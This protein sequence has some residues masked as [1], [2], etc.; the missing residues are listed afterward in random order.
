MMHSFGTGLGVAT[1][2]ANSIELSVSAASL[3]SRHFPL[4][5]DKTNLASNMH[6]NVLVPRGNF[7]LGQCRDFSIKDSVFS[8]SC[9][10]QR[11]DAGPPDILKSDIDL[12]KCISNEGGTVMYK[13]KY[14]T[15]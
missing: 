9:E 14:V 7:P 12:N 15:S 5:I 8:A 13:N 6:T 1:F 10:I 2:F 3:H 11:E 4:D